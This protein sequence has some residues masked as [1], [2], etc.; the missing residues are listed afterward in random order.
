[1][2]AHAHGNI[3]MLRVSLEHVK[4]QFERDEIAADLRLAEIALAALTAEPM[5]WPNQ[6]DKTVPTALRFLAENDRPAYGNSPYNTEHLYQL[7]REIEL[8]AMH[9]GPAEPRQVVRREH[10]QWSQSTF[11]DVGPVGP[12]KH[13]SKEA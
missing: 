7:A 1:M 6:C 4:D 5:A 8:A 9:K 3:T 12:L 10:A 2:I 11:G 13:L